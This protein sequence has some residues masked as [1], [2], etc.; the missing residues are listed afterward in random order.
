M[1]WLRVQLTR[2]PL[3]SRVAPFVV[4]VVLTFCQDLFGPAGRYW[5]YL[6]KTLLGA[7][8]LAAVWPAVR[9]MR[10]KLSGEA[11]LVGV[12]VFVM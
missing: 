1:N 7:A 4:F 11:V 8:M 9:E 3:A 10:W 2:T 6:A 5:L 12:A